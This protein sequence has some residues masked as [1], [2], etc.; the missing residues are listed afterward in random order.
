MQ[1][2]STT[3][4]KTSY[5]FIT[6]KVKYFLVLDF[7]IIAYSSQQAELC[8]LRLFKYLAWTLLLYSQQGRQHQPSELQWSIL[9]EADCKGKVW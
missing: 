1:S 3:D 5:I 7:L 8:Y 6:H 9:M 2:S 4:L